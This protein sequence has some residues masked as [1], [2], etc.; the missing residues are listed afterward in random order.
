[1]NPQPRARHATAAGLHF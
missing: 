1:M